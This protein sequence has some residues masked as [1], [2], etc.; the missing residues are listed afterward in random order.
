MKQCNNE[1]AETFVWPPL[2]YC[3]IVLLDPDEIRPHPPRNN[4]RSFI[5]DWFQLED[6]NAGRP[7]V[8]KISKRFVV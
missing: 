1:A 8:E 3:C 6:K 4:I 5:P 7:D 2:F